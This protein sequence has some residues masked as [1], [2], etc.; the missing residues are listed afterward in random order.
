MSPTRRKALA[1]RRLHLTSSIPDIELYYRRLASKFGADPR[2]DGYSNEICRE[3]R[4]KTYLR[5]FDLGGKSVLDVG[6]GTGQLIHF[7]CK[8]LGRSSYPKR[9]VGIDIIPDKIDAARKLFDSSGAEKKCNINRTAVEF[10]TGDIESM[11]E[12]FDI[13]IACSIF[14]VKQT[15]VVTTFKLAQRIMTGMWFRATEGIGADFFSPYALDIQPFNAPIP[16]EWVFTWA[17]QNLGN[18]LV[19]DYSYLPHDYAL[20]AMKGDNDFMKEWKRSGG[21]KRETGGETD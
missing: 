19:L 5:H 6:C 9:Y 3:A 10:V 14:D 13:S 12:R 7:I 8:K 15:D 18:R 21:W 20:I 11:T 17:M 16:P 4:Y 2:A 1:K